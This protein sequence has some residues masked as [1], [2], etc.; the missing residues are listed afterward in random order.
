MGIYLVGQIVEGVGTRCKPVSGTVSESRVELL[1]QDLRG[2][3]L[4]V[5]RS[6]DH[7]AVDC[8]VLED[9]QRFIIELI[10]LQIRYRAI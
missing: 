4:T 7:V 2:S 6:F 9:R 10:I 5:D 8:V 1:Y 3:A